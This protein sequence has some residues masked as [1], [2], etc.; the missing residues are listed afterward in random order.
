M[1]KK[2]Q[3][4]L[5]RAQ[6]YL[7]LCLRPDVQALLAPWH[8]HQPGDRYW[9]PVQQR[10]LIEVNATSPAG[11]LPW[12]PLLHQLYAVAERYHGKAWLP[13]KRDC[14]EWSTR[15]P[16]NASMFA[17]NQDEFLLHYVIDLLSGRIKR[18]RIADLERELK[19][20]TEKLEIPHHEADA[21][22]AA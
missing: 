20:L 8:Q 9:H 18:A 21:T 11:N 7:A 22:D 2:P 5:N 16:N 1:A 3:R 12:I 17:G 15:H 6:A 13:V 14:L 4:E 10:L 19:L